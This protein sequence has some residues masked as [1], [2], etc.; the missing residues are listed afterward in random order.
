MADT[1]RRRNRGLAILV[2]A[3]AIFSVFQSQLF[4]SNQMPATSTVV[5]FILSLCALRLTAAVA[6]IMDPTLPAEWRT[7]HPVAMFFLTCVLGFALVGTHI[8]G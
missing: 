6:V 7:R 2:I 4:D 3:S 5:A 8:C 1:T